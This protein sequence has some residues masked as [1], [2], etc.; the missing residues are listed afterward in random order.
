[1]KTSVC[2]EM[3]YTEVPFMEP[4]AKP[5]AAGLD[6][7]ESWNSDNKNLHSIRAAV[8]KAGYD[9]YVGFEFDPKA[10]SDEAVATSLALLKEA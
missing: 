1:M 5:A 3:I 7:I 6:A 8:D 9:I 10:P 2:I 4:I